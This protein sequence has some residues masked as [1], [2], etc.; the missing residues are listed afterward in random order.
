MSILRDLNPSSCLPHWSSRPPNEGT[1][2]TCITVRQ[3]GTKAIM[4]LDRSSGAYAI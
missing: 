2:L 3:L 4:T 1:Y